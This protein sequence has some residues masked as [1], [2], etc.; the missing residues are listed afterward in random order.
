MAGLLHKF[1]FLWE[2]PTQQIWCVSPG[3][4]SKYILFDNGKRP[5]SKYGRVPGF[6]SECILS[7]WETSTQQIW[8]G[9]SK[10]F[11]H[12]ISFLQ[13][14]MRTQ[15]IWSGRSLDF[16]LNISHPTIWLCRSLE[17]PLNISFHDGKRP[18]NKYDG[19]AC[20]IFLKRL[21]HVINS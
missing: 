19:V 4:S 15:Q 3:I 2:T 12:N 17:F 5:P 18:R 11:I 10:D 9:R 21:C 7:R 14:E 16:P 6:F 8:L 1:S 20:S 13:W